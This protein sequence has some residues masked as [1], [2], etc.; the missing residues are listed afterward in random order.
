MEEL[1]ELIKQKHYDILFKSVD[2]EKIVVYYPGEKDFPITW[3]IIK[4]GEYKETSS[5]GIENTWVKTPFGLMLKIEYNYLKELPEKWVKEIDEMKG[6]YFWILASSFGDAEELKQA[7]YNIHNNTPKK[8]IGPYL[9]RRAGTNSTVRTITTDDKE[10]IK[11][12]LLRIHNETD[13]SYLV[14]IQSNGQKEIIT[15]K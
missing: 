12:W 3:E 8:A 15:L 10:S 1:K 11:W 9:S 5:P 2:A 4:E 7:W 6:D 14:S 13:D